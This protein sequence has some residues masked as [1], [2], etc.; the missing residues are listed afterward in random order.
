VLVSG[1]RYYIIYAAPDD[2]AFQELLSDARYYAGG[3]NHGFDMSDPVMRGLVAS[4]RATV[5]ALE[6]AQECV[7]GS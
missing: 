6:A 2:S 4:A 5:R 1:S 3:A 7:N